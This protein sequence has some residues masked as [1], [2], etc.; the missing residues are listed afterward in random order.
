MFAQRFSS[1][2]TGKVGKNMDA[3]PK[4]NQEVVL[5]QQEARLCAIVA[6]IS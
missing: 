1:Q 6:S 4:Y 2:R 5:A 3:E